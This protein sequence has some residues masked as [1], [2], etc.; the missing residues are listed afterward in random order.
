[1]HFIL[2]KNYFQIHFVQKLALTAYSL[3]HWLHAE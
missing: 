2:Q 1:M 3:K